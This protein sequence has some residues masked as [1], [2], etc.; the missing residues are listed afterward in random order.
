MKWLAWLG[1]ISYGLCL[2]HFPIFARM[3]EFGY[4]GWTVVLI[5][6]PV[7]FLIVIVSYYAMEKPILEWKKRFASRSG[8]ELQPDKTLQPT[9]AGPRVF[10]VT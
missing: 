1:S 10:E 2:W 7:T 9:A 6:T 8:N 4:K 3:G 5:G